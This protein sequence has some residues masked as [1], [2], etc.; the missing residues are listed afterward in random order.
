MSSVAPSPRFTPAEYNRAAFDP[1]AEPFDDFPA[2]GLGPSIRSRLTLASDLVL[3]R[4]KPKLVYAAVVI[5]GVMAIVV[6]QLLLSVGLSNG[7]YQIESL[8]DQ[9]KTIDRTNADLQ[10]KLDS[11]SSP[12]NLAASAQSLGMVS[13]SNPVYLR[14]SDGAVL[15]TP[16][17]AT[18]GSGTFTGGQSSLVPPAATTPATPAAPPAAT[19][20]GAAAAG[21]AAA[22]TTP[23]AT[24]PGAP[25]A[26]ATDAT[27]PW[28]GD[29]PSPTTH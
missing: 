2:T 11:L 16:K 28:Q 18:A 4:R 8:Q 13:N 19:A 5:L 1:A 25:A 9:Q 24:T 29:L 10:E 7:A 3:R 27:V 21:T 14:L 26:A 17:A 23:A 6:T 15:G 12:Q 22:G 20:A